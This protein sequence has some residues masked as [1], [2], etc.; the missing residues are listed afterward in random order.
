MKKKS[1]HSDESAD[2]EK[3]IDETCCAR[4]HDEELQRSREAGVLHEIA[5]HVRRVEQDEGQDPKKGVVEER[6]M[7]VSPKNGHPCASGPAGG[8][9]D[10]KE[11]V[12]G[13]SP[14]AQKQYDSPVKK[15]REDGFRRK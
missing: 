5:V 2:A 7:N 15:M 8:A 9:M 6:G 1:R 3:V 11:L 4:Q 12:D 13:T 10:M 14:E